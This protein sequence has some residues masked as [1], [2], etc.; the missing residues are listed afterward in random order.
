MENFYPITRAGHFAK[1]QPQQPPSPATRLPPPVYSTQESSSRSRRAHAPPE[2]PPPRA[3]LPPNDICQLLRN[4]LW[5]NHQD[6]TVWWATANRQD[7]FY[8]YPERQYTLDIRV[9]C[10]RIGEY[11]PII[12]RPGHASYNDTGIVSHDP[13]PFPFPVVPTEKNIHAAKNPRNMAPDNYWISCLPALSSL[14]L[15]QALACPTVS[16]TNPGR[17]L[18][19]ARQDPAGLGEGNRAAIGSDVGGGQSKNRCNLALTS[20]CPI[21]KLR[22][23]GSYVV[24]IESHPLSESLLLVG[25][26][27]HQSEHRT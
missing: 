4:I 5:P 26:L 13:F 8:H 7:S 25:I 18:P 21:L 12:S 14:C 24:I 9:V 22:T 27:E 11:P 1:R 3:A 19:R 17:G 16:F 15:R 10:R 23:A 2:H 20:Y 6:Q